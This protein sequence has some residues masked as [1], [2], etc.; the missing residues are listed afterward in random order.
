MDLQCHDLILLRA[1]EG[2]QH[3]YER[4][5]PVYKG[6]CID[7]GEAPVHLIVGSAGYPLNMAEFSDK[8]GNW[9]LKHIAEYG[10]LRIVSTAEE[11]RMQFVLNK[12]GEVFD[13]FALAPWR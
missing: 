2:H 9:S 10:Y 13:E 4:T 3:S 5:C 12:N 8:Y 11:I 6:K 7:S 1:Q